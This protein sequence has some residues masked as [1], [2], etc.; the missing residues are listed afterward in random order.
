MP[1]SPT[2]G[3]ITIFIQVIRAIIMHRRRGR[4][5]V[6]KHTEKKKVNLVRLDEELWEEFITHRKSIRERLKLGFL[7]KN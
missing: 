2:R 4:S 5:A 7:K 6:M 3:W 1:A